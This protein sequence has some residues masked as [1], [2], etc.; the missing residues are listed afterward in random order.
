MNRVLQEFSLDSDDVRTL[1]AYLRHSL[2]VERCEQG[3]PKCGRF[4]PLEHM[5]AGYPMCSECAAA[6]YSMSA[7]EATEDAEWLTEGLAS[8]LVEKEDGHYFKRHESRRRDAENA[9]NPLS[10][11]VV[12]ALLLLN[13]IDPEPESSAD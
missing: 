9:D 3:R 11:E 1:L 4:A 12:D 13:R 10:K 2:E 6:W 8:G 7:D 5:H